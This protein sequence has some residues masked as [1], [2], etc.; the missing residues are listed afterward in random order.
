MNV[1]ERD[2]F[3]RRQL[4]ITLPQ[5]LRALIQFNS[6]KK[7]DELLSD[8]DKALP[9]VVAHANGAESTTSSFSLRKAEADF[10]LAIKTEPVDLNAMASSHS[11]GYKFNGTCNTVKP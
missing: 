8:L 4:S 5:H 11:G 9:H 6:H 2:I 1:R 7:W 3:L 10:G